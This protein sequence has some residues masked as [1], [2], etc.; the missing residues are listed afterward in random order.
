MAA[1]APANGQRIATRL[2]GVTAADVAL[3]SAEVL[4][5]RL[6]GTNKAIDRLMSLTRLQG[7]LDAFLRGLKPKTRKQKLAEQA[8]R[9]S[10]QGN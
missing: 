5:E 7:R 2:P 3:V 1:V 4:S 8:A 6:E 9:A 10:S